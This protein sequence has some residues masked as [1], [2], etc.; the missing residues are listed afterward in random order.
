VP[1]PRTKKTE[2]SLLDGLS[3]TGRLNVLVVSH[4]VYEPDHSGMNVQAGIPGR[5]LETVDKPFSSY[6]VGTGGIEPPTPTASR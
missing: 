5:S 6:L 2:A 3:A 1:N 4:R